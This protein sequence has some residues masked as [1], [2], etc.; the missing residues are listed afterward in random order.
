MTWKLWISTNKH[1]INHTAEYVF[2][3]FP[4][5]FHIVCVPG[6]FL[7]HSNLPSAN[8]PFVIHFVTLLSTAS[9]LLSCCE[10]VWVYVKR[11]NK[12]RNNLCQQLIQYICLSIEMVPLKTSWAKRLCNGCNTTK[13][14]YSLSLFS[15][16]F[17]VHVTMVSS[18]LWA[19]CGVYMMASHLWMK[20]S[21]SWMKIEQIIQ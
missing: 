2:V 20:N 14:K 11:E 3:F 16:W 7:F 19:V 10:C 4:F 1:Q 15:R 9:L 5:F 13:I 21:H 6:Q 18:R 8:H 17:A 12:L